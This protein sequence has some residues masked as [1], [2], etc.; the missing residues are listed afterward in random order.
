M[1]REPQASSLAHVAQGIEQLPSKQSVAGSIPAVGTNTHDM[2][3]P[4]TIKTKDFGD[5][6]V[7]EHA[8]WGRLSEHE[9]VGFPVGDHLYC[10]VFL[11]Y[12]SA[13][14]Y[15][16]TTAYGSQRELECGDITQNT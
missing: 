4:K 1:G 13:L 5:I 11:D 2:M 8:E 3:I 16:I 6:Q 7:S 10:F 14:C 12:K 15:Y 9:D